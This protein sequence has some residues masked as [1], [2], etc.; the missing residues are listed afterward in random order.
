MKR[1]LF[2]ILIAFGFLFLNTS[3]NILLP[4]PLKAD[5][6]LTYI[7]LL[8]AI[9]EKPLLIYAL[10]FS[11]GLLNDAFTGMPAGLGALGYTTAVL[12]Q[13]TTAK[14]L[15]PFSN[16]AAYLAVLVGS[17]AYSV[18]VPVGFL[19]KT[20]EF[21]YVYIFTIPLANFLASFLILRYV[22]DVFIPPKTI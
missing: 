14:K 9:E 18:F 15:F 3:F 19:I 20:G 16:L 6:V 11:F 21:P 22:K 8:Q 17:L 1:T 7:L 4:H 5:L 12:V 13:R 10:A 2:L